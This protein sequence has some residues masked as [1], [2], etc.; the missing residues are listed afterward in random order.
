MIF[1]LYLL[2]C[3]IQNPNIWTQKCAKIAQK[4]FNGKNLDGWAG[5]VDAI[6]VKD[7][8]IHEQAEAGE[9]AGGEPLAAVLLAPPAR[10]GVHL[11]QV[12]IGDV[13]DQLGRRGVV[14]HR[15]DQADPRTASPCAGRGSPDPAHGRTGVLPALEQFRHEPTFF[16]AP[17]DFSWWPTQV[18]Q[19][20]V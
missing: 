11:V 7:G 6:E 18:E 4:V 14:A 16:Y 9:L 8:A 19:P 2:F 10:E 5:A 13:L 3:H 17:S 12:A 15:P 20:G 1:P